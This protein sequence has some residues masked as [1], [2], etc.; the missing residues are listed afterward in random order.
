MLGKKMTKHSKDKLKY[1]LAKES[2]SFCWLSIL[3]SLCVC[4]REAG[5]MRKGYMG[6]LTRIANTV[7]QNAEREQEQ[8]TQL[9]KGS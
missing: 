4:Y 3:L 1:L 7:V 2:I 8:I 9:I 5:G 6:H